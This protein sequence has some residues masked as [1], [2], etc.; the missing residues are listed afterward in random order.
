MKALGYF[1]DTLTVCYICFGFV[2]PALH[3]S[4]FLN[5]NVFI[6][7]ILSFSFLTKQITKG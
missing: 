3:I 7:V 4:Y 1:G 2:L 6:N 5:I